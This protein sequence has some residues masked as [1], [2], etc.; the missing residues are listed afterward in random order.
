M[1]VTDAVGNVS[2]DTTVF[3]DASGFLSDKKITKPVGK[4]LENVKIEPVI[5][6]DTTPT[7]TYG[8]RAVPN[9]AQAGHCYAKC[10]RANGDF[11]EWREVLCQHKITKDVIKTVILKLKADGCL[12]N[13][14]ESDEITKE[15]RTGIATFQTKY[16]LP[17]GNLNLETI[18]YLGIKL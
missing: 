13:S 11:E 2:T 16:K 1:E 14:V 12:D 17:V 3:I 5:E 15:I 7:A 8:R 10:K 4:P 9:Y 6:L 18:A